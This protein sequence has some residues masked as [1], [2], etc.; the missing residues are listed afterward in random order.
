MPRRSPLAPL[1]AT[2]RDLVRWLAAA[3]ARG[4]IIGGVGASLLGRPRVTR[5]IDAVVL[6]PE[7]EWENFVRL[8]ARFGFAPR[9][10]D[11]LEF[12]RAT[13]MLL[14]RHQ[15]TEIDLDLSFGLLPFE[16]ETVARAVLLAIGGVRAPVAT[17]EDLIVMKAVAGRARDIADIEGL[18]AVA[19]EID[20]ERVRRWVKEFAAAME[21]PEIALRLE[22][23]LAASG[24]RPKRKAPARRR[25][26][27]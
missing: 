27:R 7:R 20:L 21:M 2:L 16:E 1:L 6:V 24:E 23:I 19:G 5:D 18:I 14:M 9:R 3:G 13:R 8:G 15:D 11:A 26:K 4:A 22:S 10:P 25:P 17:A 12:A